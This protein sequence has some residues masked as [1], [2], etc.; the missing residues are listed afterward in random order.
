M[1]MHVAILINWETKGYLGDVGLGEPG[2]VAKDSITAQW[3]ISSYPR[4]PKH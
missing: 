2:L 1:E 4:A 3:F